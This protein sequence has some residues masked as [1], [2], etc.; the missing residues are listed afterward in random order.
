[1]HST[2]AISVG[3]TAKEVFQSMKKVGKVH[4]DFDHTINIVSP[5]ESLVTIACKTIDDSPI[6]LKVDSIRFKE[7]GR[8]TE[9]M[10]VAVKNGN[11]IIGNRLSITGFKDAPIWRPDLTL[12]PETQAG[13]I[14]DAVQMAVDMVDVYGKPEGFKPLL[15]YIL[16]LV[17]PEPERPPIGGW[18]P[19]AE[20]ALPYFDGLIACFERGNTEGAAEEAS[21]LI[22]LGPGL[23]PSG[24]D[25]LCGFLGT[26][27]LVSPFLGDQRKD[28]DDLNRR[29]ISSINGRTN[30]ISHAYI[31]HYARG[32]PS[33]STSKMI[34]S[35]LDG[36][37]SS[38]EESIKNVCR[39]GHSSGTDIALGVLT[40]FSIMYR[41][42]VEK[43]R[44][45]EW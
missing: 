27:S 31:K 32:K 43:R 9:S 15:P 11:V 40:A 7:G 29:V 20:M 37:E 45:R 24:D 6:N 2:K 1:M 8:P 35:L 10:P 30:P 23:T 44:R 18:N 41:S 3:E 34:Q 5:E 38:I 13:K 42:I 33:G 28:I 16:R 21:H 14:L 25:F 19:Y 26:L 4:S 12:P 39:M 22:G 17:C 36:T